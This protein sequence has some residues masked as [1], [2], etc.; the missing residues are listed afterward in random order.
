MVR[1]AKKPSTSLSALAVSFCPKSKNSLSHSVDTS[2]GNK[3]EEYLL[4]RKEEMISE[5][6]IVALVGDMNI[7]EEPVLSPV[8]GTMLYY[9]KAC[10]I[11][12]SPSTTT[13]AFF[14]PLLGQATNG[15]ASFDK[16]ASTTVLFFTAR[17]R[18]HAKCSKSLLL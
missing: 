4:W 17:V 12:P 13:R 7:V 1:R 11:V 8:A 3:E 5:I 9:E 16:E 6:H 2:V 15:S 18:K 10:A 14:R